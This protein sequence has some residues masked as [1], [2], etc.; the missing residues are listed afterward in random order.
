MPA[1]LPWADRSVLWLFPLPGAPGRPL[2]LLLCHLH[3]EKYKLFQ[4]AHLKW[5]PPL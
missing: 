5:S 4:V 2:S 3:C 1:A